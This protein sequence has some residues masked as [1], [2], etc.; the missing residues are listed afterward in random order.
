M[1]PYIAVSR[2]PRGVAAAPM[3]W[4]DL[5]IAGALLLSGLLAF[6]RGL[7]REILG[8]GAWIIAAFVASPYGVFPY[9]QPWVRHQFDDPTTADIVAFAGVFLV[10]LIV[11][12]LISSAIAGLI[13]NSALGGLDRTLGLVFG[14]VRGAV[15]VCLLYVLVGLAIPVAQWPVP[16]TEARALPLVHRGAEWLADQVPARY[17]PVVAE[18]PGARATN[19]AYLLQSSPAGR[20]LG[21]RP[22]RE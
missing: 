13:R 2:E 16:V 21:A 18:P 9:L 11:L 19:S 15:L 17:R 10:V 14:L 1:P 3:N 6:A 20:A 8:L 22:A 5:A 12:W 4:V 7:V